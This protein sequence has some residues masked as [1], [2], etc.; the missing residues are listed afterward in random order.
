[1]GYNGN[2]PGT[3]HVQIMRDGHDIAKIHAEQ[4]A[5]TDCAK[6]G[7]STADCDAYITHFPCVICVKLLISAGIRRI[8]YINDYRN[9]PDVEMFCRD[10]GVILEKIE[11]SK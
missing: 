10:T 7:V 1:M 2:L 11:H 5:I 6:R 3:P 8:F 4:N 9:S